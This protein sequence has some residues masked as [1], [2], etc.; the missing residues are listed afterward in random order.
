MASHKMNM[1][2]SRSHAMFQID[3]SVWSGPSEEPVN[4]RLTL[5]DLAGSERSSL[6][7]A[8]SGDRNNGADAA[9]AACSV[10]II[11]G[12]VCACS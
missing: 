5:V 4:S 1:A 10:Q 8:G 12:L 6:T 11:R 9:A 7:G 3:V 2:S